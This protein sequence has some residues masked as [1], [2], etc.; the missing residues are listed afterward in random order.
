MAEIEVMDVDC[1]DEAVENEEK[2]DK[3]KEE[4]TPKVRKGYEM[5]W[6]VKC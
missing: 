1:S 4:P 3:M 5:P 2:T 6:W